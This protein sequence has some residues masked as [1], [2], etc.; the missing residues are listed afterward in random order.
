MTSSAFWESI[1][2]YGTI[3]IITAYFLNSFSLMATS[4]FWYSFLNLTGSIGIALVSYRKK[5]YQPMTLNIVWA[6]IGLIAIARIL[7]S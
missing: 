1:G 3:A 2:W 5:A 6:G 4:G 7:A